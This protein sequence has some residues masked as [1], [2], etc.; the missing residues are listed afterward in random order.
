[1]NLYRFGAY[2]AL[3]NILKNR[4]LYAGCV[5]GGLFCRLTLIAFGYN[6]F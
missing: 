3:K 6:Y 4:S 2:L 5:L 1:M